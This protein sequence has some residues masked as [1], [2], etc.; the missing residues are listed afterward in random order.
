MR[1]TGPQVR[2]TP[3]DVRDQHTD[4]SG[5]RLSSRTLVR[6]KNISQAAAEAVA[7]RCI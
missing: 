5:L 4:R 2:P 1:A 3:R 7:V 6:T